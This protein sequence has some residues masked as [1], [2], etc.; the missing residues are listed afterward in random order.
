MKQKNFHN[1]EIRNSHPVLSVVGGSTH[2]WY[3]SMVSIASYH[4]SY[5]SLVLY[6]VSLFSSD[7]EVAV[8]PNDSCVMLELSSL[9]IDVVVIVV[10]T[11]SSDSLVSSRDMLH[12]SVIFRIQSSLGC[13]G[14]MWISVILDMLNSKKYILVFSWRLN[15]LFSDLRYGRTI[16]NFLVSR[17]VAHLM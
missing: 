4:E 7:M 17:R 3:M 13:V 10:L 14:R 5:Y 1:M 16:E 6:Q 9:L 12:G 15:M 11:G 2:S 8:A